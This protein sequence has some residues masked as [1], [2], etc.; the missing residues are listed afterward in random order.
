MEPV[1]FTKYTNECCEELMKV[2]EFPTD[3]FLVQLI[4]VVHL[5]DKVHHTMSINELGSSAV[6]S[7]PLG[8][9]V[10]GHQAELQELK[11]SFRCEFPGSGQCTNLAPIH[12]LYMLIS[13]DHRSKSHFIISLRDCRNHHISSL[14]E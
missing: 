11:T 4:R 14:P 5:G 1:R 6:L 2:S 10:R 3:P 13:Y 7:A 8:L 9:I 12:Y